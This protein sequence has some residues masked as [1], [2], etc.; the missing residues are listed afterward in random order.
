MLIIFKVYTRENW[1][2]ICLELS[3]ES[4]LKILNKQSNKIALR[5]HCYHLKN[6]FW[7]TYVL[8]LNTKWLLVKTYSIQLQEIRRH[9][10]AKTWN[11]FKISDCVL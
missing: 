10:L 11:Y 5:T 4:E 8:L 6:E 1:P 7:I 3:L 2:D 9:Y